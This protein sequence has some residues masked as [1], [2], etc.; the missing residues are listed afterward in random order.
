MEPEQILMMTAGR[1]GLSFQNPGRIV[2]ILLDEL[3][4]SPGTLCAWLRTDEGINYLKGRYGHTIEM[5]FEGN[6][7]TDQGDV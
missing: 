5:D 1:I 6:A 4:F 7:A 2:E 3:P